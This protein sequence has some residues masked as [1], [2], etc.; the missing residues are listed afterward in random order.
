MG[1][2]EIHFEIVKRSESCYTAELLYANYKDGENKVYLSF[3]HSILI[4]VQRIN[5]AISVYDRRSDE[6]SRRFE[7][8]DEINYV[9]NS[10]SNG[11]S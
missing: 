8:F 10:H 4:E 2:T 3:I 1:R 9:E 11:E 7:K 5:K 6:T